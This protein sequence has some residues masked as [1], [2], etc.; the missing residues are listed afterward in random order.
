MKVTPTGR[1]GS[2]VPLPHA[3]CRWARAPSPSPWSRM[4]SMSAGLKDAV[5]THAKSCSN[6]VLAPGHRLQDNVAEI[7]SNL[8]LRTA[9]AFDGNGVSW[10]TRILQLEQGCVFF[11][12]LSRRGGNFMIDVVMKG[13]KEDRDEFMVEASILDPVSGPIFKATFQPRY[14]F[15]IILLFLRMQCFSIQA[16]VQPD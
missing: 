12:R 15:L 8:N 14:G 5:L 4:L 2:S 9:S 10:K 7:N 3:G 16:F 13:S 6:C 1:E 11:V